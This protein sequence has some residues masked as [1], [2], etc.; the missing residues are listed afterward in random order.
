MLRCPIRVQ[1]DDQLIW[2][3]GFGALTHADYIGGLWSLESCECCW[4]NIVLN[5]QSIASPTA[6]EL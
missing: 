4:F 5:T 6:N 3:N 2:L 1:I